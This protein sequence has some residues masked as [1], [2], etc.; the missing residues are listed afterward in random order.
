MPER[1]RIQLMRIINGAPAR[2]PIP[3][4]ASLRKNSSETSTSLLW[5]GG[6]IISHHFI[7]TA[8]H[9]FVNEKT[10][11]QYDFRDYTVSAG[12]YTLDDTSGRNSNSQVNYSERAAT[13]GA[14]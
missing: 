5:C 13:Q 6:V 7:L 12:S 10:G 9:C 11:E 1:D 14:Q 3:Y 4:Q 8:K 2:K